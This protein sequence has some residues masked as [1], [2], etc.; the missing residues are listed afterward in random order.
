MTL[1][2]ILPVLPTPSHLSPTS[3]LLPTTTH[4]LPTNYIPKLHTQTTCTLHLP[5]TSTSSQL[6]QSCQFNPLQTFQTKTEFPT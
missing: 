4:K 2:D 1:T 6:D 3:P 5:P